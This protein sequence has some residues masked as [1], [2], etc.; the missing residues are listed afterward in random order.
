V[1][2]LTIDQA[3]PVAQRL[4]GVKANAFVRRRRLPAQE[5][6]D[7]QSHLVLTFLVRWPKYDSRRASIRTFAARVMDRALWS[8]CNESPA[9]EFAPLRDIPDVECGPSAEQRRQ[10]RVDYE[11]AMAPLPGR[12]R[13]MAATLSW[14]STTEAAERFGCTRQTLHKRKREIRGAL[15]AAGIGPDYFAKGGAR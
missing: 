14:A 13:E 3:L 11:R 15:L 1:A 4:A 12:L 5:R 8:I 2:E 10:F 7:V 6:D 9:P